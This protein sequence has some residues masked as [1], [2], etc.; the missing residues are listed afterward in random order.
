MSAL[1]SIVP[2]AFLATSLVFA[3]FSL[4]SLMSDDRKFL[5]LGGKLLLT[6][7]NMCFVVFISMINL[8]HGSYGLI[9]VRC[10]EVPELLQSMVQSKICA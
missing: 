7:I 4:C 1:C 10:T 3:C 6:D 5:A 2:T 9:T 8:A